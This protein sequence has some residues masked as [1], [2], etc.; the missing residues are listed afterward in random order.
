MRCRDTDD[1]LKAEFCENTLKAMSS[2]QFVNPGLAP[3][4]IGSRKR[5]NLVEFEDSVYGVPLVIGALD[6]AKKSIGQSR[7][8]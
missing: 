4:L 6:L 8:S 2:V 5:Y 3:I 1:K 7:A